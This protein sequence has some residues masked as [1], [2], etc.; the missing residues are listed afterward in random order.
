MLLGDL[1]A[2]DLTLPAGA[3][4]IDI[5]GIS[6]DSRAVGP[7]FLF[8]ALPGTAT[9]GA[10]F[11]GE[12]V[13]RGAV[14]VLAGR[15]ARLEG[16][17]EARVLR[18][19]DPRR[20]LALIAARYYPRQPEHIVAV[21][22]TAGK[23]SVADFARQ[24]FVAA[25]K[26][27][28]SIG[29]LGIITGL[30][31]DRGE[32]TTPDVVGLHAE[33]Q[34]LAVDG[35]THVALEASSH[36]LDQRRLDGL[37]IQAAAFTNLGRDHMDYHPTVEDYFQAKLRLFTHVL[38]ADGTAVIVMDDERAPQVVAVA[39]ARGQRLIRVGAAGE[40]LRLEAL[41]AD[42]LR[43]RLSVNAF[44]DRREVSLPLL[45]AFQAT[46]ALVA[47]GLAIAAGIDTDVA[48][49]ALAGLRGPPGRLELAGRRANGAMVFVDYAHKPEALASALAALR[50]LTTGRLV[51]VFGAGGDRDPGKRPMMGGPRSGAPTPSSSPMT[52]PVR[53]TRRRYAKPSSPALPVPSRS[54]TAGRPLPTQ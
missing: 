35:V 52:I 15:D 40:E 1:A 44:A 47:A 51:V 20:A 34:R 45:G 37:R 46:N 29:T 11:A 10:R 22:G 30:R 5:K 12:A 41:A 53:R 50:P 36:G 21:T 16:T 2:A 26:P 49:D 24:I 6:A 13:G 31:R 38:P 42:G 9:D 25:G 17:G 27:S 7:G 19:D 8:A 23:T 28:A 32:L 3:G 54:P 14:A 43:Q 18:V 33:L 48:L 39:R 4:A